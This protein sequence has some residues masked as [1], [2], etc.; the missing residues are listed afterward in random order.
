MIILSSVG[1]VS[2]LKMTVLFYVALF[3]LLFV[4]LILAGCA[5]VLTIREYLILPFLPLHRLKTLGGRNEKKCTVIAGALRRNEE[6]IFRIVQ[7]L[8]PPR[9]VVHQ[10]APS[11]DEGTLV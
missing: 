7:L 11:D 9:V 6:L 3:L 10:S 4:L 2:F 8:T 5:L 1:E